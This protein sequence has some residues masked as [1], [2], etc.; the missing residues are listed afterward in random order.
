M[1]DNLETMNKNIGNTSRDHIVVPI[2]NK[3]EHEVWK[4]CCFHI[5]KNMFQYIVQVSFLFCV[6]IFSGYMVITRDSC[7]NG[8]YLSLLSS[9]MAIFLPSPSMQKK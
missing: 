6:A 8:V 5:E 4:S 1:L 2:E 7:S 3:D 9:T